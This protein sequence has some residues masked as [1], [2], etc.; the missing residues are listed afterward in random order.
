[1]NV[2][3][4]HTGIEFSATS[5]RAKNHPKLAALF[6]VANKENRYGIALEAIHNARE[7][8]VTDIDEFITIAQN[9]VK[10][11]RVEE[12]AEAR[13]RIEERKNRAPMTWEPMVEDAREDLR[14]MAEFK[15][16]I[17]IESE[18]YG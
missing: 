6:A 14:A 4:Q 18:L 1:M 5:A 16:Q 2:K 11:N 15:P 13:K 9:A 3:C 17:R 7:A 12:M 10:N 8:G